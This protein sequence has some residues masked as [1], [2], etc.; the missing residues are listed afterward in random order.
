MIDDDDGDDDDGDD[1]DDD[2][3]NNW[4]TRNW[5]ILFTKKSS[6]NDKLF[7][8]IKSCNIHN[9]WGVRPIDVFI[10]EAEVLIPRDLAGPV[11][12][13]VRW[14]G[15][16]QLCRQHFLVDLHVQGTKVDAMETD[17]QCHKTVFVSSGI[18]SQPSSVQGIFIIIDVFFAKA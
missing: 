14:F 4:R 6:G 10:T 11:L 12:V 5:I 1:D 16:P 8:I 17:L 3:D 18:L 9:L 2:D 15:S 13:I 7:F